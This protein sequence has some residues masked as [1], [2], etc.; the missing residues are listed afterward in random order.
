MQFTTPNTGII[1]F[2]GLGEGVYTITEIEA[3]SGYNKLAH[4]IQV[5]ITTDGVTLEECEWEC[6]ITDPSAAVVSSETVTFTQGDKAGT[7][8]VLALSVKN[9]KGNL[10]PSTG[11]IGTKLFY[12]IG[13]MLIVGSGV[14]LVAKKRTKDIEK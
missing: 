1:N 2:K 11:G 6:T 8:S 7:D 13:G 14:V 4:P 10:L 9:K 12:L 5:T 3:P